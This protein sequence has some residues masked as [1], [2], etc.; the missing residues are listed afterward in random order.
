MSVALWCLLVAVLMPYLFTVIAKASGQ[1]RYDNRAPR[2][3]LEAQEG[4]AQ[5]ADWAQRNSFEAL[6]VFAAAVL[7]AMVAGVA[8]QWLAGLS[9]AFIGLR[10]IY[11]AC[12]LCDWHAAR[13]TFWF[14]S[15]GCC[16]ALLV[17]AALAA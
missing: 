12:Y 9:L 14:A 4:L 3:Y 15:Y 5:R 13:S 1:G 6:P 8:E 11:G 17:M 10:V 16:L 2:R 7:A